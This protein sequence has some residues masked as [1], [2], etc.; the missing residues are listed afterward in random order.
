MREIL[1]VSATVQSLSGHTKGCSV[2]HGDGAGT[3]GTRLRCAATAAGCKDPVLGLK[4]GVSPA[5]TE[6]S[7]LSATKRGEFAQLEMITLS[8][9]CTDTHTFTPSAINL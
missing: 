1:A 6:L 2:F 8:A 9:L 7:V 3:L 4:G 5:R